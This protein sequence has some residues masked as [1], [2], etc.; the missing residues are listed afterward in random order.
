MEDLTIASS[1]GLRLVLRTYSDELD[2]DAIIELL[3]SVI[4]IERSSPINEKHTLFIMGHIS[5]LSLTL[6]SYQSTIDYDAAIELLADA[7]RELQKT[8]ELLLEE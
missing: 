3:E 6:S 5:G 7:I 1:P 4:K 8:K 2:Y